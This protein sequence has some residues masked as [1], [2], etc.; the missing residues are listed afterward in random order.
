MTIDLAAADKLLTTTRSVRK[1]L[2]LDR[3]VPRELVQECID[4]AL[5]APTGTNAQNWAFVVVTDADKRKAIA[6]YYRQ[7]GEK[8]SGSGYP[9]PLAD[10]DPREHVMPKVMESAMYL[11]GILE[12]V[13]VFVIPCVQGRVEKVP[14]VLAQASTY[15]GILPAAWSFMLAARA[16]GLGTAW[17]TIH[18]FFEREVSELLGIPAE[19][20]QTALFPVAY[21][22]GDDFKPAH[23]L[24]AAG[25][26]HW[27]AW[28]AHA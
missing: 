12:R 1:R 26:T 2:D 21:Y 15:G 6:D 11:A 22:T 9:P 25:V 20:T 3:P 24:P 14:M 7:G 28:G 18:L 10:G 23:R 13:P 4:V 19:W 17:T 27:D 5:Q 8:L 16:R